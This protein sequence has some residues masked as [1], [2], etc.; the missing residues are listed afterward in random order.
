[1]RH[2]VRAVDLRAGNAARLADR[3]GEPH[4]YQRLALVGDDVDV[5]I[6]DHEGEERAAPGQG[7][8]LEDGRRPV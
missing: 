8:A 3:I 5:M 1:M 2:P 4:Q 7:H 6:L